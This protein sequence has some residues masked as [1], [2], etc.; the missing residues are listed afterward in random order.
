[1]LRLPDVWDWTQPW[2]LDVVGTLASNRTQ[3]VSQTALPRS[4]WLARI[5]S[6]MEM[7]TSRGCWRSGAT[8]PAKS[9]GL[10]YAR[11]LIFGGV[12]YV[13]HLS[14]SEPRREPHG[15]VGQRDLL[16][17]PVLFTRPTGDLWNFGKLL[18]WNGCRQ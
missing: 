5:R 1:V 15:G 11:R 10:N 18:A 4:H 2:P 3:K 12:R 9:P 8:G 6:L 16:C 7:G 14:E 17:A 13:E